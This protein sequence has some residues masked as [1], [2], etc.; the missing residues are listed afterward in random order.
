[1]SSAEGVAGRIGPNAIIRVAEALR[2][3][4][5]QDVTAGLFAQAGLGHYLVK[6]PEK[7]VNEA[8]VLRLH[9][10]LRAQLGQPTCAN[11][12]WKAGLKTADYLLANRIPKF[13]Q[14]VFKA[15]PAALS[16]R[17][18][19]K[20]I[21]GHSW[22]FAGSGEFSYA[23]GQTVVLTIRNNPLCRE[24]RTDVPVCDFYS[25]TFERLFQVLVHPQTKVNETDCE[26][27]GDDVCRFELTWR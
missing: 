13:A 22:T 2:E 17:M 26:A 24:V 14:V 4:F 7:M 10:V 20:T 9:N 12:T 3:T 1:M 25:A 16:A 27:Q 21:G 8:E 6:L 5:G 11:I 15:L 19:L 18:L 23:V